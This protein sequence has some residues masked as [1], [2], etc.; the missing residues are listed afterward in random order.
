MKL[1]SD[2]IHK[3]FPGSNVEVEKAGSGGSQAWVQSYS[4]L[5][6]VKD[7]WSLG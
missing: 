1:V 7:V 6:V 2:K 5:A 3:V 4:S